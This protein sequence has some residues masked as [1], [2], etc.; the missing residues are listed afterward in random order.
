MTSLQGTWCHRP[1]Q[2]C[3]SVI[4]H[5]L[6]SFLWLPLQICCGRSWP[7]ASCLPLIVRQLSDPEPAC[8]PGGW[9]A[10]KTGHRGPFFLSSAGHRACLHVHVVRPCSGTSAH[11]RR[12]VHAVCPSRAGGIRCSCVQKSV[13]EL[14]PA[15]WA[16]GCVL[17]IIIPGLQRHCVGAC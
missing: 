15:C 9:G 4:S 14:E 3:G 12:R 13:R 1:F 2:G 7:P 6:C 8:C 10:K 16:P 5:P 11:L 17:P